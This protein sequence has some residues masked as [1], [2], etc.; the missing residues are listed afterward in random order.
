MKNHRKTTSII[1][2]KKLLIWALLGSNCL[3]AQ[4]GV[5]TINPQATLH[6]ET[7]ESNRED[8]A[9]LITNS[10]N[11]NIV[12]HSKNGN[13]GINTVADSHYITLK[14]G[15]TLLPSLKFIQLVDFGSYTTFETSNTLGINDHGEINK[16]LDVSTNY[17]FSNK[18]LDSNL[19]NNSGIITDGDLVLNLLPGKYEIQGYIIYSTNSSADIE[20]GLKSNKALLNSN[21]YGL[22]HYGT[23]TLSTSASP[24]FLKDLTT[25]NNTL[26]FGGAGVTEPMVATLNSFVEIT[27]PTTISVIYKQQ[28][29]STS[30]SKIL[31]N[32]SL[33]AKKLN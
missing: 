30:Y 27:E 18:L 2:K 6:I 14:S 28:A 5:G 19:F 26:V 3:L 33:F 1:M 12:S 32:S 29:L 20:I 7:L 16:Q 4:V 8:S 25:N 11:F 21:F 31:K 17:I 9:F 10:D 15:N 23:Y 22:G 13:I 24:Y